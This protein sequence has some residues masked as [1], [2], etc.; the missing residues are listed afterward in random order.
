VYGCG[1]TGFELLGF[2]EPSPHAASVAKI[3]NIVKKCF[4]SGKDSNKCRIML[5]KLKK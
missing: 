1:V 3:A 5:Y 2:F 4:I